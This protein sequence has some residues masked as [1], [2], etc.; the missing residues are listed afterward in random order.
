MSGAAALKALMAM[1]PVEHRLPLTPAQMRK[2]ITDMRYP[3][4]ATKTPAQAR[5]ELTRMATPPYETAASIGLD[6]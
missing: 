6:A 1:A 4:P 5:A 3:A 2:Q